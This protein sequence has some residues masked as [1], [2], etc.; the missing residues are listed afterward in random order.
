MWE[1]RKRRR[2]DRGSLC[3]SLCPTL[4]P[5]RKKKKNSWD[6]SEL[7]QSGLHSAVRFLSVVLALR[8]SQI[9]AF[10]FFFF[11]PPALLLLFLFY[12][13]EFTFRSGVAV[14]LTLT[15]YHSHR[16]ASGMVPLSPIPQSRVIFLHQDLNTRANVITPRPSFLFLIRALV[17]FLPP[18]DALKEFVFGHRFK[19]HNSGSY[20]GKSLW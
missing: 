20:I 8:A 4:S 16:K 1:D 3:H 15:R 14:K 9:P 10:F 17:F 11:P 19:L 2:E 6:D 13:S 5:C 7:E 18:S 12:S